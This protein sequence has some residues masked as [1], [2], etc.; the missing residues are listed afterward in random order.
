M[1]TSVPTV[2]VTDLDGTLL[3]S[4]ARLSARTRDG[5]A[6]LL[7]DGL[8]LTVASARSVVAMQ[9]MLE[10]LTLPLPVVEF[11]G[12][13]VSDLATGRH[14][15]TNALR[16]EVAREIYGMAEAAGIPPLASTFDGT[17]DRLYYAEVA[18]EG[19]QA[20][21]DDR[22]ADGDPR[23]THV[24]NVSEN[25]SE[26]VVSLTV[27]DRPDRV[28]ALHESLTERFGDDLAMHHFSSIYW[29]G[30]DWMTIH[31]RR[32][33]KDQGV[34]AMLEYAG[35]DRAEVVALGDGDSDVPLFR[36]ADRAVAMANSTELALE[37][38]TEVIGAN[39]KDGVI[40]FLESD[41]DGG[42]RG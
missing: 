30:W 4:D 33:T 38:A 9:L 24:D 22:A 12:A 28:G 3:G 23:L 10:G 2:Y 6:Q 13:F 41:W 18:N 25:V 16:P 19:V 37:A 26:D 21:V 42:A 34:A 40:E 8:P 5:L 14:L 36:A 35:L 15:I 11:H 39:T 31:D 17:A 20:Y 1:R 27:I 29:L 7:D 32:A